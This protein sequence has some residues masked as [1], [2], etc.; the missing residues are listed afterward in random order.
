MSLQTKSIK[1]GFT[2]TALPP[3]ERPRERLLVHGPAVLSATELVAVVLSRGIA[4]ESVLITAR[5]LMERFG[6]LEGLSQASVEDI[7]IQKGLGAAKTAQ[8]LACMEIGRRVSNAIAVGKTATAVKSAEDVA[9]YVRPIIMQFS[10][11]HCV[12]VSLDSRKHVIAVD[13]VSVGTLTASLVHP[14]EIFETA[15]RR[16]AETVVLAHNHPSGDPTPSR[17]DMEVTRTLR[18]A[19]KILDI[20]LVDHVIITNN[21]AVS[22]RALGII[23]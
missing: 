16:H 11:E 22:L 1:R 23:N 14:R 19:G 13:T 18:E 9:V 10:K 3:K 2:I 7:R 6:S 20:E 21:Q 12:L 4:G 5:K 8:I 17:A 15:I